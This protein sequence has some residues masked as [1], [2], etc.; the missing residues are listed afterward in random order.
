MARRRNTDLEL[1][2]AHQTPAQV[3][4][5][6]DTTVQ[7]LAIEPMNDLLRSA[8]QSRSW[9]IPSADGFGAGS[10][11]T[12]ARDRAY[13][14]LTQEPLGQ[15]ASETVT[16]GHDSAS[17]ILRACARKG[18]QRAAQGRSRA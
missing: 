2:G 14:R 17:E 3:A 18:R 8:A 16:R 11:R 1:E 6:E 4:L 9:L 7:A 13:E 12:G 15:A 10:C 5:D